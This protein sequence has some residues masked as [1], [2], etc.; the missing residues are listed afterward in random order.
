MLPELGSYLRFPDTGIDQR[1]LLYIDPGKPLPGSDNPG[2]HVYIMIKDG[3]DV[4]RFL[5]T[6]HDRCWLAGFGWMMIGD[7][8]Q[9]VRATL[10]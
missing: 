7:A 4:V 2:Q 3:T 5:T 6:L 8:G 9:L 1:R 10:L